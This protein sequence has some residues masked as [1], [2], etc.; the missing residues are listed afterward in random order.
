MPSMQFRVRAA[1][2]ALAATLALCA[3]STTHAPAGAGR[4][5]SQSVPAAGLGAIETRLRGALADSGAVIERDEA[6]LRLRFAARS[7]FV[8]D[9]FSLRPEF[10]TALDELAQVLSGQERLGVTISVYTD[11]MG[12]ESYNLQFSQQRAQVIA[13]YLAGQG[14]AA[15]RITASGGGEAAPLATE[16]TP[17]GRDLNRRV[18]FA[19]SAL[20]S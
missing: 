5:A 10:A 1:G 14:I 3:C 6:A 20:S 2:V 12:S 11:A 7:A 19:I 16:R 17:E 8:T 13:S 15:R 18:E 4:G 9:Q